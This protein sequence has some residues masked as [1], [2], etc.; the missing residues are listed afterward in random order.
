MQKP[1]KNELTLQY[2]RF[3][4]KKNSVSLETKPQKYDTQALHKRN[5]EM[6]SIH[7]NKH[8]IDHV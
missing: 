5:V 7:F 4:K 2:T 6:I 1:Y 3:K 8:S